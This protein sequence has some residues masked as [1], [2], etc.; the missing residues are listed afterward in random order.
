MAVALLVNNS[1]MFF[2]YN[3]FTFAWALLILMLILMPGK[4]MP[5]T[6]IWSLL[7]FDKF[8]H[9]FV[10]AVLVFLL[11]IGLIKQHTYIWLRFKAGK[12]AL[13][14]GITYGF[15]LEF[16]QSFIPDRTFDPRD[17]LANT[18]GCF[19]GSFLFYMVYKFNL[20]D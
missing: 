15:L 1:R 12:M 4:N 11:T 17:L 7:T 5:D 2:R 6:N 14:S 20:P 19:L 10:F 8:A 18:I 16:I 3:V 13:I 9:F